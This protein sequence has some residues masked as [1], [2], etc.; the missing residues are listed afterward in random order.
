MNDNKSN[1]KILIYFYLIF[2]LVLTFWLISLFEIIIKSLTGITNSNIVA[3]TFL[4]FI[5][6]IATVLVIAALIFPI[7]LLLLYKLKNHSLLIVKIIFTNIII[8]QYALT[9]YHLTTLVNLG[10]D[11]LGYSATDIFKTVTASESLSVVYFMPFIIFPAIFWLSSNIF[12]KEIPFNK[13]RWITA[14]LIIITLISTIFSSSISDISVQNK[15]AFFAKDIIRYQKDKNQFD[16]QKLSYKNEYPLLKSATSTPDVLSPFFNIKEEKP[17]IV[18]I[19]VEG[20]GSE[21][22]GDNEYSGFT[23]FLDGLI[24]KSLYWKNFVSNTGRTFGAIPSILGSLP[25]GENGFLE[26]KPLPS[27]NSLINILKS[28]G[29]HTAFYCGDESSFDNRIKFLENNDVD[30]VVDI[31]KFGSDFQMTNKNAQG[32]TWGYPDAEIFKKTLIEIE[33]QKEPRLDIIMTLTNHEPFDFPEKASYLKKVNKI[34]SDNKKIKLTN[35]QIEPYKNIFASLLYTDHSI[36]TFIEAY[37]KRP[38]YE[39]TIF[40]ITG[41][42]RLIPI[43]QKDKLC[44]FHVPLY[45][46]SPMLKKTQTFKSISSHLDIT[47]S[48]VSFLTANYEMNAIKKT[49]WM[50]IGLDTAKHFRNI[51]TIPIMQ[52]KG[53]I[54]EIIYK[55]YLLSN[56]NLFSINENFETSKISN[57]EVQKAMTD[58][59][60]EA[61]KLNAYLTQKNKIIPKNLLIGKKNYFEFSKKELKF[62][63]KQT[64]GLS[65]DQIFL[66]ARDLAIKNRREDA[67]VLCD[68]ILNESPNYADA[69]TLKGRTL[70]WDKNYTMAEIELLEVVKRTPFYSDSYLALMDIYWWTN[71]DLK[72]ILLAKKASKNNI[73]NPDLAIKL[74]RSYQRNKQTAM[75][76][77]IMDSLTRKYPNNL[78]YIK[79]KKELK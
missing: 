67:R 58:S 79:L 2:S 10:A 4:K 23:P 73:V 75:A 37:A 41:D 15:L 7:F 54:N 12:I 39:N 48:L 70:G 64:K 72:G 29:Y 13:L 42:H 1:K 50:S 53:L 25:Y 61:K 16:V 26:L 31:D 38:D 9:R 36:K 6:D 22:I 20:L 60:L 52:N 3:N 59:L 14:V 78:E 35:S 34:I 46:Y 43:E 28:N 40:I 21:F 11:I 65:L 49:A 74:T 44:R 8:I 17:N 33:K 30:N 27:H 56:G 55:N 63:E 24:S 77:K 68:Y 45:I 18:L 47:P 66:K 71:Q 69:R 5:N 19:I 62:I 51:H 76:K 57:N 32:F